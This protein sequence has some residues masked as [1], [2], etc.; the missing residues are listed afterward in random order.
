MWKTQLAV[1]LGREAE[2]GFFGFIPEGNFFLVLD[3]KEGITK[4][5]GRE[6]LSLIKND[7]LSQTIDSL[8]SFENF[9]NE[10]IKK[11]N[12]P[13]GLSLAAGFLIGDIFY[14]KTIGFGVIFVRRNNKLTKVI[15]GEK[16][17][18]GFVEKNDF[19]VLTTDRFINLF[20]E[21]HLSRI[22]DHKTPNQVVE[23][24]AP[25][26]KIES[27]EGTIALFLQFCEPEVGYTQEKEPEIISKP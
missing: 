8:L 21:S 2:D 3:I 5:M 25:E 6:I 18:S 14:L 7:L 20:G 24:L 15:Q 26:M 4:E 1:Y 10:E 12:L 11:H 27:D 22:F 17:A 16:T 23:S 9:I 13:T 19:F